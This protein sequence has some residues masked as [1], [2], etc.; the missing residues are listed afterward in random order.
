M[1]PGPRPVKEPRGQHGPLNRK[2]IISFIAKT[3]KNCESKVERIHNR[4]ALREYPQMLE[5]EHVGVFRHGSLLRPGEGK[6][7]KE[8]EQSNIVG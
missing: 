6:D 7:G 8:S 4:K 3:S 2:I 1:V 5:G